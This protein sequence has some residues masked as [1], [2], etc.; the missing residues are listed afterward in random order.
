MNTK[1][2]KIFSAAIIS[3]GLATSFTACTPEGERTIWMG[4]LMILTLAT[5]Q[6]GKLMLMPKLPNLLKHLEGPGEEEVAVLVIDLD[7]TV[8]CQ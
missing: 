3:C 8:V 2:Y 1:I 7:G 6:M 5:I 4:K